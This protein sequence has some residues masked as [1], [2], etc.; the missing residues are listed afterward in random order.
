[1]CDAIG[2]QLCV[3]Q[4][5][6]IYVRLRVCCKK[7]QFMWAAEHLKFVYVSKKAR[8]RSVVDSASDS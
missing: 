8:P 6:P 4:K 7:Y 1:M 3:F 2:F 5:I